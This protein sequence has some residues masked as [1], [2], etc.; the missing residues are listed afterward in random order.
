LAA[1][2][3]LKS[4]GHIAAGVAHELN[5]PIQYVSNNIAFIRDE[6]INVCG[7]LSEYKE[8]TGT[9]PECRE[10][11]ARI[12]KLYR[13][14]DPEYLIN[15][16]PSTL[17]QTVDGLQHIT[18]IVGAMREYSH[19]G[20]REAVATD[21]NRVI[22]TVTALCRNDWKYLADLLLDLDS[23]LPTVECNQSDISQV[24]LNMIVNSAHAIEEKTAGASKGTIHISTQWTSDDVDIV[25]SDSGAGIPPKT[26]A[27][28]FDP[29]FTTKAQG[30]GTGQGLSISRQIIEEVHKGRIYVSSQHGEGTHFT[31]RL[32]RKW[33]G[34]IHQ[35]TNRPSNYSF[36]VSK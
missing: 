1:D 34:T 5:T 24:I 19:P 16:I 13:E 36:E 23:S 33:Q 17:S 11:I 7:L 26:L 4:L 6:L 27:S 2:Q 9:I 8:L 10:G 32:P 25:I 22:K 30:K 35:E 29:F 21:I 28:I 18:H 3:K 12:N 14:S 20:E 31:I 15:E